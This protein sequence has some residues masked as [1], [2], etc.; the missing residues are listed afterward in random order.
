MSIS[1]NNPLL[2]NHSGMLG[3]TLVIRQ[4]NGKTVISS[5]PKKR[6]VPTEHQLKTKARFMLAVDYAKKQM[7]N[8]EI[9]AM[10][11][12]A[13]KGDIPNAYTAALKDFLNKPAVSLID[14]KEYNG[15][16]GSKIHVVAKD[17]FEVVS[18]RVDIY[19]ATNALLET[20][21]AAPVEKRNTW[22]YAV[23]MFNTQVAGSRIVVTA[24]DRPKNEGVKEV[25]VG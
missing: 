22:S 16:V 10:Y 11:K 15:Q 7:A 5:A 8:P 2:K 24:R 3:K 20:G 12:K 19:D 13:A 17:D 21:Y 23:G 1:A 4:V 18:V 9:K 14:V 25:V 6:D